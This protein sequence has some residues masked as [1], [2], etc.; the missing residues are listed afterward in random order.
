[1]KREQ[2][3]IGATVAVVA[4]AVLLAALS[5]AALAPP[6]EELQTEGDSRLGIEEV[7]IAPG[8]VSSGTATLTVETRLRHRGSAAENVTVLLRAVDTERGIVKT[9]REFDVGTVSGDR[10][11][12]I[13]GGVTVPRSGNYRIETVV[14]ADGQRVSEGHTDVGG[15]GSLHPVV[16]Q[17][18][19]DA[20]MA[21][22][23]SVE[24]SVSDAGENRTSLD[25]AA[26]VTNSDTERAESVDVVL[27]A[28]QAESNIVADRETVKVGSIA[29]GRTVTPNASLTVPDGYNYYL[30]AMIFRDDVLITS[31]RA[32]A[33]L[34]PGQNFSAPIDEGGD[35]LE[36]GEFEADDGTTTE[37]TTPHDGDSPR[38]GGDG[39]P[40]FGVAAALVAVVCAALLI[41]RER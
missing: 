2:I 22:L 11:T 37:E 26:Y 7:R 15:V 18:F 27:V 24:Y 5:P 29:S 6:D 9:T 33:T 20:G 36:V 25:V 23:P 40:G 31:T 38:S 41:R 1:M 16:F 12:A 10:E 13:E 8:D 3:L 32:P 14:F 35:E 19:D 34:A 17:E 21:A 30:D 28:R 4:T 39:Q